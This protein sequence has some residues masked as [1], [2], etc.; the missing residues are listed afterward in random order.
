M[1]SSIDA[2]QMQR[3]ERIPLKNPFLRFLFAVELAVEADHP[4]TFAERWFRESEYASAAK[5]IFHPHE[6]VKTH[7]QVL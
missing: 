2:P 7:K 5:D 6:N 4:R 3:Q 1:P